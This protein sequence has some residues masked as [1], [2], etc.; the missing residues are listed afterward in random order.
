M[1]T[2][3]IQPVILYDNYARYLEVTPGYERVLRAV[4]AWYETRLGMSV[5]FAAIKIPVTPFT[6]GEDPYMAAFQ[7]VIMENVLRLLPAE[8]VEQKFLV[9]LR[10]W[11][12]GLANLPGIVGWGADRLTIMFNGQFARLQAAL[13]SAWWSQGMAAAAD[14]VVHETE[15]FFNLDVASNFEG[16]WANV[17]QEMTPAVAHQL[18]LAGHHDLAARVLR[19]WARLEPGE[20]SFYQRVRSL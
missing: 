13:G 9:L 8:L 11:A 2:T 4:E 7:K 5:H 20:A 17:P 15:H 14:L 10:D 16:E 18:M 12:G 19:I 3:I 1:T 6:V